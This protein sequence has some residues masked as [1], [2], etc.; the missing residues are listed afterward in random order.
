MKLDF[1][2]LG[3]S[4]DGEC[5][6]GPINFSE[7]ISTLAIVGPSGSGKTTLLRI[8]GG[9]LSPS[10]GRM[11]L[12]GEE[13]MQN[14]N[15]LMAYRR[16]IGYVFQAG[17]LFRHMTARQNITAPLVHVH[18]FSQIEAD[19]RADLLL[20]RF[21]LLNQSHKRPHALSGGEQQRIAIA[22]AIAPRPRLLLLDEPT[23]ALDPEFTTEVL[24]MVNELKSD[25][26]RFIIVTHE[27]G[28]ARH[29]CE[30]IAFLYEGRLLEHGA[31][32]RILAHPRTPEFSRFLGKLLEWNIARE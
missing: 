3:K 17:G 11:L 23:S 25:G 19:Q 22:R 18:G 30:N 4:Y 6:L 10:E 21:G 7:E 28:F 14:E 2:G 9:L 16:S 27:M 26:M 32:A 31:S 5:V 8:V 24:D 1:I 29:A 20:T 15:S 13:I 12:D